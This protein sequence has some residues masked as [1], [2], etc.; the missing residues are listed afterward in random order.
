MVIADRY[1][2]IWQTAT[3]DDQHVLVDAADV[4]ATTRWIAIQCPEC[5]TLDQPAGD[6]NSVR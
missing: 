6:W 1:G 2:Q 3:A 5:E 4:L